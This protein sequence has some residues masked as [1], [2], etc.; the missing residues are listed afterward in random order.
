MVD[1][2]LRRNFNLSKGPLYDDC[3]PCGYY[4]VM[5]P[6][7]N[8]ASIAVICYCPEEFDLIDG[9]CLEKNE[10]NQ[11][12]ASNGQTFGVGLSVGLSIAVCGGAVLLAYYRRFWMRKSNSE[13]IL[14]GMQD[15]GI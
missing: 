13:F 8:I 9:Q 2:R 14:Y 7:A 15:A 3:T 6:A 5:I 1:F 4:L 12:I 11:G 10:E